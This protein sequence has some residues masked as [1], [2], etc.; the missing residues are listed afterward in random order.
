MLKTLNVGIDVG[1][2]QHAVCLLDGEGQPA[3]KPFTISNNAPG[4]RQLIQ[5]LSQTAG[6][7]E[8]VLVGMEATGIYWWHLCQYLQ[9]PAET[10]SSPLQV[11]VFNPKLI[12]GF[13]KA[14]S[15]MEKT[16]PQD[17]FLIAERLRF[18]RLPGYPPSDPRY[19]PLQRLTRYRFHLVHTLVRIKAHALTLLFLS[20]SE[21]ERLSPFADPF[22]T[23]SMAVLT[24]YRSLDELA[25]APLEEM[26]SLLN[27]QSRHHLSDP[28][29][30]A[31]RLEQ[32]ATDSFQL[33][34][35]AVEPLHF[36]LSAALNHIR[37]LAQQLKHLNRRITKELDRFPNTL[38]SVP[39]IGPVFAA[40]SSP[41]SVTSIALTTMMPWLSLL[42]SGGLVTRPV[43]L[44][45]R[46]A[47]S[48]K[49]AMPTY[50]IT[51]VKR[52]TRCGCTTR[53]TACS[54]SASTRRRPNTPISEPVCS[55]PANWS[56][57]SLPCSA[58]TSSTPVLR[59]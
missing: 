48:P 26:I 2:Q 5:I 11:V 6:D 3:G 22:G 46:T 54:T 8:R 9:R 51:S 1:H 20:A 45:L 15:A 44:R 55:L 25:Q 7:C 4:A 38:L 16:D 59:T 47:I 39:G 42:A 53:H 37:F 19:F 32:I 28:V 21:Y 13:R 33:D 17:A 41:R 40:G 35:D 14:Y 10:L 50:A 31:G 29:A 36:A 56:A 30:L 52:P 34:D 24:E 27:T 12:D 18:G 23:T 57:W 49:P 58:R 43:A